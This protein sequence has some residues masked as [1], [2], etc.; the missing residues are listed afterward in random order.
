MLD[1]VSYFLGAYSSS[2][3]PT[4]FLINGS[5]KIITKL[6]YSN[7]GGYVTKGLGKIQVTDTTL[8]FGYLFKDLIQAINRIQ[9]A[10]TST[11]VYAQTGINYASVTIGVEQISTVETGNDLQLSG[12]FLWMYDGVRPVEQNF[13][14]W[15]DNVEC[16]WSATGGS[17]HAQPDGSTNTNAYYY[18][19][20]YEWAD[21]Q[22]NIFR[23]AP[24][25]PVGVTTTSTGTSG[26]ITVNVPSLRLT[27]KTASANLVKI[28]I[29]RWS[30]AQQNYY[31]VTSISTPTLNPNILTTDSVAFVDTLA[32]A[33]IVGNNLI[34]TTGGVV[35]NINGPASE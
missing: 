16:T 30:V 19:V 13:F 15:P 18:Q 7:G 22:G 25:I 4:C 1:G 12:G 35:E 32:D 3:Q 14:V 20:T 33:S 34:Y 31:Q 29:Y 27:Y 17:I 26:S 6:A 5:G 24:S 28:V 2:Y 23:S 10:T 9:G 8:S 21:N 11:G